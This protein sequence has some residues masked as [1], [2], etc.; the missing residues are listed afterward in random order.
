[1]DINCEVLLQEFKLTN[2]CFSFITMLQSLIAIMNNVVINVIRV[3]A[4][5]HCLHQ[6]HHQCCCEHLDH[7][8]LCHQHFI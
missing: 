2:I 8:H 5:H 1:M 3:L 4:F 7:H 6:H